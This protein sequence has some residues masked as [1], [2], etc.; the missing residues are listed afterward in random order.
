MIVVTVFNLN[1]KES[2]FMSEEQKSLIPVTED[3]SSDLAILAETTT[4]SGF[5][6]YIQLFT[7]KATAVAEDKIRGGHYGLVQDGN[8]TDLGKEI[9]IIFIKVRARAFQKDDDGEIIVVFDKNDP[10]FIRI[11]E[12]QENKVRGCMY[13]PEFLIWIPAEETFATFFCGS[14][15]LRREARKFGLYLGG[16]SATLRTKLIPKGNDKWHGPVT[17]DCSIALSPLPSEEDVLEQINKF[18]NPLKQDK[19]EP[20]EESNQVVR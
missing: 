9:N 14:A 15:T 4:S 2:T 17:L 10:E 20:V 5:L 1:I 19:G 7:T 16:R 6:P 12:L 13:G 3:L 11:K 8:I 18:N